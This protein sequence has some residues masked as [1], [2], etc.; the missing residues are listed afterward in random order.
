MALK[1]PIMTK[2]IYP[3]AKIGDY[4]YGHPKLI[5]NVELEIGRYTSIA[6]GVNIISIDHRPDWATTYPFPAL[7]ADAQHIQGH[8]TSRG[9]VH[10]GHDVWIGHGVTILSGVTV[11]NGA[12]IGAM[13]VVSRDVAPYSVVV[14][15]PAVHKKFRFTEEWIDFLDRR[16]KWW[17]WPIE[18]ILS[19]VDDLCKPPS[20][21]LLK[22]SNKYGG[23]K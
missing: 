14:G 22:Y 7:F 15:N 8:P 16:L 4:T 23:K 17:D 18:T 21:H 13:S 6:D 5:G 2:S 20:D 3:N 1:N 19:R 10:I 11:G 9:A 12:V